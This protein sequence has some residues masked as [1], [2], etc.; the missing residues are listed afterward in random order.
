MLLVSS[1]IDDKTRG[2]MRPNTRF[3]VASKGSVVAGMMGC[4][5]RPIGRA[6]VGERWRTCL[7]GLDVDGPEAVGGAGAAGSS[8]GSGFRRTLRA[9]DPGGSGARGS[10]RGG[11]PLLGSMSGIIPT[12]RM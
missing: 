2:G 12:R 3:Q 8:S 1:G 6:A 10:L 7:R 9:R 5:E 11:R 4:F